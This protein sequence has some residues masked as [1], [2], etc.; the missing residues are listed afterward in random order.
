MSLTLP[1]QTGTDSII[2]FM[3]AK[4]A[5]PRQRSRKRDCSVSTRFR[6]DRLERIGLVAELGEPVDEA[7]RVERAL[8]PFQRH[9]AVGQIDARQRDVGDRRQS[10][11]DLGHAA[12]AADAL[13]RKIDMRQPR[14]EVLT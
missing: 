6:A 12:G 3:A 2:T 4:A 1:D 8:L 5:T 10:A 9:A 7:G 13:D 14:T 11:L